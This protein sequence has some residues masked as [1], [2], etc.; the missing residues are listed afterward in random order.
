MKAIIFTRVATVEQLNLGQTLKAQLARARD[1]VKK[2]GFVIK[3]EYNF[4][5]CPAIEKRKKFELVINEIKSSKEK[6]AVVTETI[7]SLQRNFKENIVLD[8]LRKA[9]KVELHFLRE[10]LVINANSSNLEI[11]RWDMGIMFAKSYVQQIRDN[12]KRALREKIERGEHI[13]RPRKIK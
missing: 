7:D 12:A 2:N 8:E 10:N 6:I 5:A 13:G 4:N 9:D 11:L 3:S 1:Y